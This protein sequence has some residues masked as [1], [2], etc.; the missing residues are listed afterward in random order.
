VTTALA[1]ALG[2]H[3]AHELVQTAAQEAFAS[4]RPLGEVLAADGEVTA[5]VDRDEIARL[6]DPAGYLGATEALI[7]RALH[8]HRPE[9]G[10]R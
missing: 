9:E 4:E 5:H 1:P 3:A 7:D 2:R 10:A 8:A 6:L